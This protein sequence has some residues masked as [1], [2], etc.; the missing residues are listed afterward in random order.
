MMLRPTS[1]S[2]RQATNLLRVFSRP[3]KVNSHAYI[4]Y[5]FSRPYYIG[6]RTYQGPP[7]RRVHT[8]PSPRRISTTS[9]GGNYQSEN[10]YIV[11]S[12]NPGEPTINAIFEKNTGTWQ[13]IVADPT[14]SRAVI[15][16]PVLDYDRTT[17]TIST[18]SADELL[19][20]IK[21]CGYNIVMILETHVHADHLTAARYLQQQLAHGQPRVAPICI[22]RRIEYVQDL[23]GK[24]YRIPEREYRDVFGRLFDDDEVF[25]IGELN[26]MAI[27]LPGHT[28]DHLGY[29][30]GGTTRPDPLTPP[31]IHPC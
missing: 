11:Q 12:T 16:D 9:P 29:K 25:G 3:N 30:I 26:A 13:Y 21:E 2:I 18:Q 14:T 10:R 31:Y 5:A 15:I 23:F 22:G 20:L 19:A 6:A 28:P 4:T 7:I 8:S 27:H 24:R 1:S 17:Q